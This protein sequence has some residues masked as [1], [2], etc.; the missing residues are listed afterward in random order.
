MIPEDDVNPQE[1]LGDES[2]MALQ[3]G[4]ARSSDPVRKLIME[5]GQLAQ[6]NPEAQ[7]EFAAAAK[8]LIAASVKLVAGQ[9]SPSPSQPVIGA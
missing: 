2:Q 7:Q 5:I 8:A 4:S 3:G 6:Q 9:Q 1:R